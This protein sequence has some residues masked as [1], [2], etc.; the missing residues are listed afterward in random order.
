MVHFPLIC[1]ITGG[2]RI[3]ISYLVVYGANLCQRSDWFEATNNGHFQ[4]LFSHCSVT[5]RRTGYPEPG[6]EP[7]QLLRKALVIVV[8]VNQPQAI[9]SCS[10]KKAISWAWTNI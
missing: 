3:D 4:S 8:R 6:M 2:Q 1:L 5:K 7:R 9:E 10:Q